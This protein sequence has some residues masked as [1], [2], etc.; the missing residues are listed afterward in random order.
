MDSSLLN[1]PEMF[2]ADMNF[3]M[4]GL[5]FLKVTNCE[6]Q[7]CVSSNGFFL[8]NSWSQLHRPQ[9]G[10]ICQGRLGWPPGRTLPETCKRFSL[11]G[12][13]VP[14]THFF[15]QRSCS[16]WFGKTKLCLSRFYLYL[17]NSLG[18]QTRVSRFKRLGVS[19]GVELSH[20]PNPTEAGI[21]EDIMPA[22][23]KWNPPVRQKEKQ[24]GHQE[25]I[26]TT[27]NS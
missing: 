26:N 6:M 23:C 7:G 22:T 12:P 13:L 10:D 5:L 4:S 19:R 3:E 27:I 2:K 11:S 1:S 9:D 18:E 8:T 15:H 17:L 24:G 25:E 14:S 21:P 16:T 20:H